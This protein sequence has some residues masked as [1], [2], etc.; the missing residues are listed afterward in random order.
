MMFAPSQALC[1]NALVLL[2]AVED[3]HMD[4]SGGLQVTAPAD[5]DGPAE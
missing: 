3:T 2:I 5:I 4:I 1:K